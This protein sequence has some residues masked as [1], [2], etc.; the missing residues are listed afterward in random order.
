MQDIQLKSENLLLYFKH[1]IGGKEL[2]KSPKPYVEAKLVINVTSSRNSQEGQMESSYYLY[3][4]W[5]SF[6]IY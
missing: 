3:F 6:K 4:T 5:V 2:K 1:S